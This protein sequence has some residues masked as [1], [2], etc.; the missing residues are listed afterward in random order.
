[1]GLS[2]AEL[3]QQHA[4]AGGHL[5]PSDAEDG[6]VGIAEARPPRREDLPLSFEARGDRRS[7]G[8]GAGAEEGLLARLRVGRD[9]HDPVTASILLAVLL[10]Q[11]DPRAAQ[12]RN[13]QNNAAAAAAGAGAVIVATQA[14]DS[15]LANEDPFAF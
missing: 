10:A 5:R 15:P 2:G 12:Q 1:R 9:L 4:V 6:D 8:R 14:P 11:A 7:E 13:Q 3:S